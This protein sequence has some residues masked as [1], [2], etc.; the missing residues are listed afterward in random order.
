MSTVTVSTDGTYTDVAEEQTNSVAAQ[1]VSIAPNPGRDVIDVQIITSEPAT[2]ELVD[3]TGSVLSSVATLPMHGMVT[4]DVH[5][6]AAGTY[7]VR[8]RAGSVH[9]TARLVVLP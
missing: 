4:I 5:M 9:V 8:L 7:V 1:I 2:I 6:L 3:M